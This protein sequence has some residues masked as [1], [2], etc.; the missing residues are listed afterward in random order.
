MSITTV[1]FTAGSGDCWGNNANGLVTGTSPLFL[2]AHTSSANVTTWV[3]FVVTLGRNQKISTGL[4]C[5]TAAV[6]DA[7]FCGIHLG[8]E[9]VDSAAEPGDLAALQGKVMTT[10]KV[11]FEV[12]AFTGGIRYCHDIAGAIQEVLNRAGWNAGNTMAVL[13]TNNGTA[14]GD[15]RRVVSVEGGTAPTLEI[16]YE[17]FVPQSSGMF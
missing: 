9:A 12:E 3:P 6:G 11:S 16:T 2:G 8:C 1:V 15:R 14:S 13:A 7:S 10:A 4:V 5:W 17:A